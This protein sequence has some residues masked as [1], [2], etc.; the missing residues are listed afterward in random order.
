MSSHIHNKKRVRTTVYLDKDV[1]ERIKAKY[2]NL[3][4]LIRDVLKP[5]AGDPQAAVVQWQ[6]TGPPSL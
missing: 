2:I 6:D 1:L 3:S 4:A 5:I